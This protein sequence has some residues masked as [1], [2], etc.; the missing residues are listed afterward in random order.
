MAAINFPSNPFE[1]QLLIVD[2]VTY[3]YNSTKQT[4]KAVKTPQT[5][6]LQN[7]ANNINI[8]KLNLIA[9]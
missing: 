3:I 4:W 6:D 5:T 1:G 8:Y 2:N 7:I 9:G